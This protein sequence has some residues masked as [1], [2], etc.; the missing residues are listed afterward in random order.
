[1]DWSHSLLSEAEQVVLRRLGVFVGG[2]ALE[3][4]Q[5]VA[6]DDAL[7]EW[8]VLDALGGL[9]DKSLVIPGVA[10]GTGPPRYSLL[11]T[12]RAYALEQLAAAG[13]T[14]ACIARHAQRMCAFFERYEEARR[15]EGPTLSRD[16]LVR[17]TAPE[18][19]NERAALA[20][21]AS[22]DGAAGIETSDI[23]MR[24]L[25][26]A[27]G[28]AGAAM[29]TFGNVSLMG[30][31]ADQLMG[32]RGRLDAAVPGSVSPLRAARFWQSLTILGQSAHVPL[33][34]ALDAADR[35]E[36]FY[37]TQGMPKRLAYLWVMKAV[38]LTMAGQWP[39][40]SQLLQ[41]ARE[42]EAPDWSARSIGARLRSQAW[43]HL[44]QGQFEQAMV[45]FRDMRALMQASSGE[46]R[47]LIESETEL[48]RCLY[49]TGRHD[50]CIVLARSAIAREGSATVSAM[51]MLLRVLML[52][53]VRNGRIAD[54]CR[55]LHDAM[56]RWR[57]Y[58]LKWASGDLAVVLAEL[59]RWADAVRVGAAANAY[60]HRYHI[61][62]HPTMQTANERRE[63]L[64]A[65]AACTAEDLA[66]WQREGE[67]LDD[68]AIEA[69]CL[70]AVQAQ[71]SM[72]REVPLGHAP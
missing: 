1:M 57:R 70:R 47:H 30:E 58:G 32:L 66:R 44:A 34:V 24:D 16:E 45:L 62:W 67:M 18:L 40:A 43:V 20:W 2:F 8:A 28:L 22:E 56:P 11:E 49:L 21:A 14:D 71:P 36:R 39:V 35:A 19:D 3:L 29:L 65:A 50:E 13:E 69:I 46:T 33:T 48:C 25:D 53:Q 31:S 54:A 41:A 23:A 37:R 52:A 15:G 68:A 64:L 55:T 38:V 59:G 17:R 60:M 9:V 6:Q 7:D 51:N 5:G 10:E 63:A 42:L 72:Q 12:T 4:A 27:V 61:S 26:L